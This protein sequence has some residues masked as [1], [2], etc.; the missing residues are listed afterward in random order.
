MSLESLLIFLL[1]GALA[2]WLSGLITK[3]SGFGLL[4]NVLVGIVG[5][6]LGG[7][8]FRLLGI[9]AYGLL[10]QIIFAVIGALIFLYLLRFIKK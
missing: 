4:G 6:F 10:G 3:G 7:F 8:L 2:G 5:A 9:V 1:V